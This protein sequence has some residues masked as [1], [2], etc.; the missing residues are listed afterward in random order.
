MSKG[1]WYKVAKSILGRAYSKHRTY[2]GAVKSLYKLKNK[3][4][5]GYDIYAFDRDTQ[6]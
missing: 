5:K 3:G 2:E 6:K 4:K 1:E